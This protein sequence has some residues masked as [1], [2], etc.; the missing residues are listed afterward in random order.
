MPFEKLI[1]EV[2][3]QSQNQNAIFG[4]A[5]YPVYLG[6]SQPH[7][8]SVNRHINCGQ[9]TMIDVQQLKQY[10]IK[11]DTRQNVHDDIDLVFQML[12]NGLTCIT[13]KY[14]SFEPIGSSTLQ[15]NSVATPGTLDLA[16][17]N[18]Y[19]KYR[20]GISLYIGAH[21]ELRM[22]TKM[23]KYFNTKEIP[24]KDDDYHRKMYELCCAYNAEGIKEL[25]RSKK[26]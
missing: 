23:E 17:I 9:F 5:M 12:Q 20:D 6:F 18:L 11:Y 16:R 15:K 13:L 24:I 26:K 4:S 25:I 1:D 7:L 10:D 22:T 8:I 21:N 3:F 2:V 19:L 14:M